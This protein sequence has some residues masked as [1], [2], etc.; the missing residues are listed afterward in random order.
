VRSDRPYSCLL[1]RDLA[2]ADVYQAL[3]SERAATAT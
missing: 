3:V 2:A 1:P